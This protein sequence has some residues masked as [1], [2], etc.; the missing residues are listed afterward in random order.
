MHARAAGWWLAVGLL[1]GC[2]A[3]P[4]EVVGVYQ[5]QDSSS[6]TVASDGSSGVGGSAGTGPVADGS[7]S[8]GTGVPPDITDDGTTTA[9]VDP[10]TTD[11]DT[12]TSSEPAESTGPGSTSSEPGSTSM[13]PPPPPPTCDELFGGA[14]GYVLCMHD[15]DS[16]TFNVNPNGSTCTTICSGY[17]QMCLGGLDNPSAAGTECMI[18]GAFDCDDGSGKGSTICICSR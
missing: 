2:G 8:S 11:P 10:S 13:E 6:G 5:G 16:C 4:A 17:G 18:Q 3:G 12:S 14:S 15:A 1:L 9:P 7:A